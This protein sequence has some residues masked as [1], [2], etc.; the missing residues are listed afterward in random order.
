[1]N[2][3]Y[4]SL[5]QEKKYRELQN[6][7]HLS[8]E[9]IVAQVKLQIRPLVENLK[10]ALSLSTVRCQ[11]LN[12]NWDEESKNEFS[13][14]STFGSIINYMGRNKIA[15]IFKTELQEA[16]NVAKAQDDAIKAKKGGAGKAADNKKKPKKNAAPAPPPGL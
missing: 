4:P 12:K 2:A 11:L 10:V 13:G 7:A 8:Q 14:L 3:D 6:I 16:F 9:T 1:M 5:F 15:S